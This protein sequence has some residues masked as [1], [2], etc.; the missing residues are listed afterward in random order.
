MTVINTNGLSVSSGRSCS[1]YRLTAS[2]V[3]GSCRSTTLSWR[4]FVRG[5]TRMVIA[6]ADRHPPTTV[7]DVI[8]LQTAH[9]PGTQPAIEHQQ[10]NR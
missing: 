7:R 2:R 5:T 9:L 3:R 1:T 4:A 8:Q 10:E 6:L